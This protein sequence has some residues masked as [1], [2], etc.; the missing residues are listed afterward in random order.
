[1]LV[2][3]M[4]FFNSCPIVQWRIQSSESTV[5]CSRSHSFGKVWKE[6]RVCLSGAL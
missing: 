3:E 4:R 1:M 6:S 5:I 2:P